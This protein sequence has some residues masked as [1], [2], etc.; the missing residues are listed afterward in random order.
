MAPH[1]A[2]QKTSGRVVVGTSNRLK[3]AEKQFR[4]P[5]AAMFDI[6]LRVIFVPYGVPGIIFVRVTYHDIYHHVLFKLI[7]KP[8]ERDY[9]LFEVF[10][11]CCVHAY[12]MI[13]H[14]FRA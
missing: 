8:D 7:S 9:I 1:S 4:Y 6:S 10:V 11:N 3:M 13:I 2:E 5:L 14:I 12:Y